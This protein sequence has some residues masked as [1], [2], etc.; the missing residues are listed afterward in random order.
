MKDPSR[1][2]RS[3]RRNILDKRRKGA[4]FSW[5]KRTKKKRKSK[6]RPSSRIGLEWGKGKGSDQFPKQKEHP[7]GR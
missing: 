5:G 1:P 2:N 6:K 7:K 4:P 3:G